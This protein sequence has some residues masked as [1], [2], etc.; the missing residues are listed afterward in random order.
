MTPARA[1]KGELQRAGRSRLRRRSKPKLNGA[2]LAWTGLLLVVTG[3]FLFWYLDDTLPFISR[4]DPCRAPFLIFMP[5]AMVH[6]LLC[7]LNIRQYI[8]ARHS[9]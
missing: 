5:V 1:R 6:C 9:A 2:L 4:N 8:R 7:A 3:F